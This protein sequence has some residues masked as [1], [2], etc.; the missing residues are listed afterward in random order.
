MQC[1]RAEMTESTT[2]ISDGFDCVPRSVGFRRA[3]GV[4]EQL[5]ES[6]NGERNAEP[7]SLPDETI[8]VR[9]GERGEDKDENHCCGK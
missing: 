4:D 8:E 9:K 3:A 6:A 5:T 1:F 7:S 2:N